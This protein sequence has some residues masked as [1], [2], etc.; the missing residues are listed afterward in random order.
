MKKL[1]VLGVI[2]FTTNSFGQSPI[3]N[4]LQRL[5]FGVKGGANYSNFNNA[6]FD[7]DALL[8]F[9]AGAIV[10][11]KL[12]EGLSIQEEFLFSTQGAK[13]KG[14]LWGSQDAKIYYLAVPFLL[15]YR[16]ESGI[17]FEAGPQVGMKLKEDISGL[18]GSEFAKKVD[19]AAVGGL[20]YQTE[21]GLGIGA[22]YIYG[23]SKLSNLDLPIIKNDFTNNSAQVSIFYL[24]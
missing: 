16:T 12:T 23:I 2:L 18:N 24:F 10:G 1:I 19:V 14:S 22:R 9:H 7:T 17:Y 8:G 11:L 5:Q 15:K 21:S 3:K 6:N 20:G 4:L 13:L